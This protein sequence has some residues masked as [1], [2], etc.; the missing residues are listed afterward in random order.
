M[1]SRL[2]YADITG[3]GSVGPEA[4]KPGFDITAYWART[5]LMQVTHDED[6]PPTNC[7]FLESAITPRP[8][9]YVLSAIVTGLYRREKDRERQSRHY[10]VDRGRR[11]G[12]RGLDRRWSEWRTLLPTT[13]SQNAAKRPAEP[14]SHRRQPLAAVGRGTGKDWHGFHQSNRA[15]KTPGGS[16]L[17]PTRRRD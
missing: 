9:T 1:N 7:L 12:C 10:L 15:R 3:Y 13:Q 5:G 2:I 6:S 14:L 4:D 8:C 17:F 11:S 16:A